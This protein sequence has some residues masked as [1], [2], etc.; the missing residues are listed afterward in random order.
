MIS[1]L[2]PSN[3]EIVCSIYPIIYYI[4]SQVGKAFIIFKYNSVIRR[5]TAGVNLCFV[6]QIL[7]FLQQI[8][9][10]FRLQ[11]FKIG[12]DCL[13]CLRI[14]ETANLLRYSCTQV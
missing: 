8:F 4:G 10:D 3:C 5:D 11:L 6:N 2:K 1:I 14:R 9:R 7:Y 13:V 12:K